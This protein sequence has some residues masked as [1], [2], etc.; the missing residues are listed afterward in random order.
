MKWGLLVVF[1]AGAALLAAGRIEGVALIALAWAGLGLGVV[2][3]GSG[4]LGET[5]TSSP[6]PFVIQSISCFYGTR[7]S[8]SQPP[9]TAT[10]RRRA[11]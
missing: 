6:M 9:A 1:V 10:S 7:L 5:S 2:R 8:G 3:M 4:I 11:A